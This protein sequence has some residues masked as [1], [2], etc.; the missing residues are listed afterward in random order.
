MSS[1][2]FDASVARWNIDSPAK[3]PADRD[4]VQAADQLAVVPGLDA[5]RPPEP[6]QLAVR[7]DERLV[8]PTVRVGPDPRTRASPLRTRC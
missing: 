3:K 5:V 8:D 6:V 7:G 4:A 2:T 1:A